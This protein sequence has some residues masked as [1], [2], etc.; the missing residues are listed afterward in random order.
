MC[1]LEVIYEL[2]IKIVH[3]YLMTNQNCRRIRLNSL[4]KSGTGNASI[5]V[6][7]PQVHSVMKY[8][9]PEMLV[10]MDYGMYISIKI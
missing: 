2:K 4:N 8:Y 7:N 3:V 5:S 1:G 10:C 6:L 9:F